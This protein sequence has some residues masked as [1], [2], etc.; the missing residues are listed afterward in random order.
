MKR[1]P[2][3]SELESL[4]SHRIL[5]LDGAMG[6][7]I[8]R[9][10]LT[11]E[12]FRPE[13]LKEHSIPLKGN[14]ELLSIT[15][16]DV[17]EGIHLEFIHAGADILETN[18]FSANAISQNDYDLSSFNYIDQMNRTSVAAARNAAEQYYR[19]GGTRRIFIAG[20]LGPTNRTASMSPDVNNPAYRAV[21]FEDLRKAYYDQ[22]KSLLEAGAEML[23]AETTFDTLNLKAATYAFSE[24][25]E[26]R[27]EEVPVMLSV[28]ITDASGRTL[29][30]Q[31]LK[32][33][34]HS[35]AH[36]K[37]FSVGLNC[38]L[39]A[40]EMLPYTE[41]LSRIA[42]HYTS[43][44]PNAGLPNEFGGYDEQ[45]EH[46]AAVMKSYAEK[47]FLNIAGG[48][49]GTTP[50]FIRAFA[51]QIHGIAPRQIPVISSALR[52]SG[53]EPLEAEEGSNFLMIG[54]RTNVAGSPKFKKLIVEGKYEEALE[55]ARQQVEAGANIIDV[56][57]DEALLDSV[58]AMRHFLNLMASEPDIARIP[59]MIDSSRFD[60][61]EA[62]LQVLQGKGIVNSISLKEGEEKFLEQAQKILRYGAAVVVMAFDENGQAATKE[63]KV[64]ISVRAYNLLRSISFPAED[65][66]FDPN[67]LT[68]ATGMEEHSN[69]AVDFIEA[70]R[71]IKALCPGTRISGGV[72][73]ISFSFRGNN[74]VREAMHSAFL[75]HAGRA[76]LDMGIVNAGM[77][78][79]YDDIDPELRDAVED[80]LLNRRSDAT[81]RLI[82]LSA[83]YKDTK[84]DEEKTSA[85]WRDG[86]YSERL[87]HALIH[88]LDE[89]I[90]M[91]VEEAYAD[92]GSALRVIEGP[93]MDGMK[94]VGE[95]FGAG[96]MFLPQV[97]KTARVMKKAVAVLE[98]YIQSARN[99]GTTSAQKTI[100]MAT[101]KG[102]VHDIGKNIVSVVLAS[103][104]YRVVDLGVMVPGEKIIETAIAERAD[105]I[106]L[107]GLITPSLEEMVHVARMMHDAGFVMP[108]LIGG[109]TTSAVHTAV[110][111]A[112]AYRGTVIHVI[113]ASLVAGVLSDVFGSEREN[114]ESEL[115]TEQKRLMEEFYATRSTHK[116][117]SY[118]ESYSRRY[119]ALEFSAAPSFWGTRPVNNVSPSQLQ[120]YIDWSPFFHTW[121]IRGR[122]P[123]LLQ[124]PVVGEQAQKLFEDAK[125]LLAVI[126][127]ESLITPA[128]VYGFF[129][130]ASDKDEIVIFHP[131]NPQKE[132]ERMPM[133]RQQR[134]KEGE[135]VYY[136]LADFLPSVDSGKRE[137]LG[138]FAVTAGEDAEI[139][140]KKFREEGDEYKAILAAAISDRIAES[141]AE[142]LHERARIDCG[143]QKP[144][145]YTTEELIQEKYTG[146]RPAP[147]YPA[148]PDHR[149]KDTVFRLLAVTENT[150]IEL[151]ESRAMWPASSVSGFYFMHPQSKY[152]AVGKIAEDQVQSYAQARGETMEE[153]EKWLAP[154]L[155]YK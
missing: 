18:T 105:A 110:K 38:S 140:S 90:S 104:N 79:V 23:L 118:E 143:L 75:Y 125:Q 123:R 22:A 89:F 50:D 102:D 121:S 72:S 67:I 62:G 2:V 91:D 54:E 135:Q 65:I 21:T 71:E 42:P 138:M 131:Q 31:T 114:Y 26:E 155:S 11:E 49:C 58:G 149:L 101:V 137:P 100:I 10:S 33:F 148:C 5:I 17:I 76:G 124:D 45:P 39:G 20:A 132:I 36:S 52:L 13:F 34:W 94:I 141:F 80:V 119:K 43:L 96:K 32:A 69:Y 129:P 35:M 55:I 85:A 59:V 27:G 14:N 115:K 109:A 128:G 29:S 144:N 145:Q 70:V 93:L 19:E 56:N 53:L 83:K 134:E 1:S 61:I 60:V 4:L 150:G 107:S 41:E 30:G 12:D 88:G 112:P 28:T 6:T 68:V 40:K 146:I 57:F 81:E 133:L 84:K 98:P 154:Y 8:Q 86:S 116:L 3:F 77:L 82:E 142:F 126:S 74:P 95:Y 103:N 122:Y 87:K 15:R 113:D 25:F 24:L 51:K 152:F 147:G 153:T 127:A 7:M 48:C 106:G 139:L 47:G 97:V 108:L 78:A 130:A 64:R 111:I 66:I 44:Y 9:Y 117:L 92:L 136:S 16:P 37:P 99:A 46:F 151:T 120:N 63:D 73:N